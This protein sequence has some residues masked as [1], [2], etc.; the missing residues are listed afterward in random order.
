MGAD[1]DYHPVT[2]PSARQRRTRAVTLVVGARRPGLWRGLASSSCGFGR[3]SAN[4]SMMNSTKCRDKKRSAY[5]L[6]SDWERPGHRH[7]ELRIVY[8]WLAEPDPYGVQ[9]CKVRLG[10][11]RVPLA[12]I[13]DRLVHPSGHILIGRV[14]HTTPIDVTKE[15]V[16]SLRE[17]FFVGHQHL[18]MSE[19]GPGTPAPG[20]DYPF[21]PCNLTDAPWSA[22]QP[23][24][25]KL[26][27]QIPSPLPMLVTD[28]LAPDAVILEV[29][30]HRF[31]ALAEVIGVELRLASFSPNIEEGRDSSF[32]HFSP[33]GVP[34]ALGDP[35][36]VHLGSMSMSLQAGPDEPDNASFPRVPLGTRESCRESTRTW[37]P[38]LTHQARL[39]NMRIPSV[40]P[41]I[42]CAEDAVARGASA[43]ATASGGT[44]ACLGKGREN[45]LSERRELALGEAQRGS[46]GPPG[47][48]ILIRDREET[49][50]PAK[51]RL[52]ASAGAVVSVRSLRGRG[53]PTN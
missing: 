11:L 4:Q 24:G 30:R 41:T 36:P 38:P 51:V 43:E 42:R 6:E 26:G 48:G 49:E 8:G 18:P 3:H 25:E 29:F 19:T 5:P 39:S 20:F 15:L 28:C 14:K 50:L 33:E 53:V 2:G 10:Q 7:L 47:E 44:F 17:E 37:L 40:S 22:N 46:D 45:S 27:G 13:V 1:T 32:A 23:G 21:Q 52:A 16:P 35:M 12:Q 34:V 9:L 31:P